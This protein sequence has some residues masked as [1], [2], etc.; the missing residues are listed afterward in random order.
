M[1]LKD[2]TNR[3]LWEGGYDEIVHGD[4][5][6]PAAFIDSPYPSVRARH[7]H[8]TGSPHNDQSEESENDPH[9]EAITPRRRHGEYVHRPPIWSTG[10]SDTNSLTDDDHD[11]PYQEFDKLKDSEY[12]GRCQSCLYKGK[13]CGR[14]LGNKPFIWNS[15]YGA[16]STSEIELGG[17]EEQLRL[18]NATWVE[19]PLIVDMMET[20]DSQ[21]P[22]M[23]TYAVS[24]SLEM[25]ENSKGLTEH[26]RA[27]GENALTRTPTT[28]STSEESFES[29]EE[30]TIIPSLVQSPA[31][32]CT[33][34]SLY[35]D[36]RLGLGENWAIRE[37]SLVVCLQPT[38]TILAC[39]ERQSD[40]FELFY[41]DIFVVCRMYADMWAL[42]GKISFQ[43]PIEGSADDAEGDKTP[44]GFENLGFLPLCSVTLAANFGAFNRRH[45]SYKNRYPRSSIF[46]GGGL[47]VTPPKRTYSLQASQEIFQKSKPEIRL[48]NMVFEL[49]NNFSAVG[50]G[51]GYL[52]L[53]SEP[54][55]T[56]NHTESNGKTGGP[57]KLQKLWSLLRSSDSSVSSEPAANNQFLN[58][59][60]PEG[61]HVEQNNEKAQVIPPCELKL[62]KRSRSIRDFLGQRAC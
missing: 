40:E 11:I 22:D 9:H 26:L 25:R 28:T 43:H 52:P 8:N 27:L 2:L 35:K 45:S 39:G 12:C 56:P 13:R 10:Q 5:V 3:C 24:Q 61:Q 16:R 62:A 23:A 33:R 46:P 34:L 30:R 49:C 36:I 47:Q 4:S 29:H 15:R 51:I 59:P 60:S 19:E 18:M 54:A 38:Y 41:G 1:P 7:Y 55:P 37:G 6:P 14:R 57:T 53:K 58:Q 44:K 17:Y 31:K 42:C 21:N 20:E 32:G 48:P 50:R